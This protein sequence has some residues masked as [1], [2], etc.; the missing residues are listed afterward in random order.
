VTTLRGL[1]LEQFKA[2]DCRA[3]VE[4]KDVEGTTHSLFYD[5]SKSAIPEG[6]EIFPNIGNPIIGALKQRNRPFKPPIEFQS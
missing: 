1:T 2:E 3:E 5:Q 6:D 4:F